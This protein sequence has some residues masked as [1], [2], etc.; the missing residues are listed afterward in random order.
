MMIKINKVMPPAPNVE[1]FSDM[2]KRCKYERKG[3]SNR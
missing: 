2:F 1:G 3:Y